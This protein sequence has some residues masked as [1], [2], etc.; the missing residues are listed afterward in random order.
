[1]AKL[2]DSHS[3]SLDPALVCYGTGTS[4]GSTARLAAIAQANLADAQVWRWF[5]DGMEDGRL[6]VTRQHGNWVIVVDGQA[7]GVSESLDAAVRDVYQRFGTL[8]PSTTSWSRFSG[9]FMWQMSGD[10]T[11]ADNA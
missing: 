11:V 6:R 5:S 9:S 8:A 2:A 1:M 4:G 10:D 7:A 3:Y